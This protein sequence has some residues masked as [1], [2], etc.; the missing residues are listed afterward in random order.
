MEDPKDF[1][2][3]RSR[4]YAVGDEVPGSGNDQLAGSRQPAR[5]PQRRVLRQQRNGPD[6]FGHHL[7]RRI[8]VVFGDVGR[9]VVEILEGFP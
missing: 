9:F 3:R 7:S 5:M 8:R 4:A 6:D 1:D 2:P